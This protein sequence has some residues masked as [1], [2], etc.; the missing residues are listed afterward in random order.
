MDREPVQIAGLK[1]EKTPLVHLRRTLPIILEGEWCG[2]SKAPPVSFSR[3]ILLAMHTF[4]GT[5]AIP[6]SV[7]THSMLYPLF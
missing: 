4:D 2:A 5:I 7:I 3:I 1:L 6:P